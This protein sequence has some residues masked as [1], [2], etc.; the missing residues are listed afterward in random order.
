MSHEQYSRHA[1]GANSSDDAQK[2]MTDNSEPEWMVMSKSPMAHQTQELKAA[3]GSEGI[4]IEAVEKAI[5]ANDKKADERFVKIA[6]RMDTSDNAAK[7]QVRNVEERLAKL[8]IRE[9]GRGCRRNCRPHGCLAT[10][11]CWRFRA[12]DARGRRRQ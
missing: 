2:Q 6:A 10:N 11:S 8:R 5:F 12:E 1:K 9:T 3:V 7:D 4:R